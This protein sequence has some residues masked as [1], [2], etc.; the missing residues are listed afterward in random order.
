MPL[1]NRPGVAGALYRFW[2]R[3][4]ASDYISLGFLAVGWVLIQ[5]TAKPFHQMFTLDNVSIQHP[6]AV[7]ERV[8]VLWS[9]IYAGIIP[10]L[11]LFAWGSIFHPG[12]HKFHVTVLGLLVALTLSSFITDVIKNA[13]GR[14]RPDLISRCKPEKGTAEHLLVTFKVCTQTN[15]HILDEGWRSFPSG[16]S[17][18]SFAG[19][20]YLS[21]FLAGQMHVLRPG[22]DL[23]RFLISLVPL[24]GAALI[25]M[26]RLADYRHDVYDVSC[27]T[28][29][30]LVVAYFSY[31]RY[32]PSLRSVH[33]DVPYSR[34]DA[35][36][37]AKLADDEE[38][39][40]QGSRPRS[41]EWGS[42]DETHPLTEI[43]SSRL[44]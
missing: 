1:S 39:H 4:Y 16:H 17:S 20:G 12:A 9:I 19:L 10:L 2:Q 44:P 8:P 31:R 21:L 18:F 30:G 23:G 27:G 14:P 6:F 29:L 22:T 37:F 34:S 40:M 26:S 33:C 36:G 35:G 24:M 43:S 15:L 38:R 28:L 41:R 32:Y 7:V 25:A 42:A 5:I 11:I 13:V 3:S